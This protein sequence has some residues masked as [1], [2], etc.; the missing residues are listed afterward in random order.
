MAWTYSAGLLSS[1]G[2]TV[3]SPDSLL[4]GIAIAQASNG[5][6]AYRSG[7]VAWL[8]NTEIRVASGSFIILDDDSQIE[9]TGAS[10]INPQAGGVIHGNRSTLILSTNTNRIDG[11][12]D[13]ETGSTFICRRQR[14]NDPSPKIVFRHTNRHDYPVIL[15]GS[16]P[17]LVDIAGLD[18]YNVGGQSGYYK[19]YF[20]RATSANVNNVRFFNGNASL[21]PQFFSTTYNDSYFESL[22][23]DSESIIGNIVLNRTS[24]YLASPAA[25]S[26]VPR[27]ANIVLNNT[28][29][30][31]NCW[32]GTFSLS[33][34]DPVFRFASNYSYTNFMR[35]G[36]TPMQNVNLQFKR[37]MQSRNGNAFFY[38]PNRMVNATSNASGTYTAPNLQDA[39]R[40]GSNGTILER[41]NWTLKARRYD[42]RTA[43]ETV[44][45][46]RVL[47]QHSVNMSAGYSEEVQMLDVPN[48][49][50]TE[51]QATALTGISMPSKTQARYVILSQTGASTNNVYVGEVEVL[52][53]GVN[54]SQGKTATAKYADIGGGWSVSK[55]VDGNNYRNVDGYASSA[56]SDNWIQ[57]D[58]GQNYDID[59]ISVHALG[60]EA[61]D[62]GF[63]RNL[64]IFTSVN[65]L[66]S[67][68]YAQLNAGSGGAVSWGT[69]VQTFFAQNFTK[70]R[71]TT[72]TLSANRTVAELW[73]YYRAWISQTANFDVADTWTYN[74]TMLNVGAWNIVVNNGTTLTGNFT[75]TGT[76]TNNGTI[77][78]SY[79]DTAGTR[80]IIRTSDNLALSTELLIDGTPQGWQTGQTARVITVTPSSVVRIYAHAYGYQPKIINITGN[81]AS[82]Y[83]I[84]LVP[85]TNVDT[86]QSNRDTIAAALG[87]GL[88]TNSRIFLSVNA[89]LRSYTPAQVLH[90]LHW[91]VLNQG[92]VIALAA[93]IAGDL[94]GFALQ[95][96]GFIV[97]TP[98]FYGKVADSVTTVGNLGILVPLSIYV[99]PSVYVTMPTYTAVEKN[100][101][102]IVLQYAPWT[103]QEAD[104][105]A[106]VAKQTSLEVV[107]NGVKKAS[108]LIP[109]TDNV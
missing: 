25:F 78:G 59:E 48:L 106:W 19:M 102:G 97:R 28:T 58:L 45:S 109:H 22:A 101:S 62:D 70:T 90:A 44:F 93:L 61:G 49:T 26:G 27:S 20:G 36:L 4:S 8:A 65:P 68:T 2:A 57:I 81:T 69:T 85:E 6:I 60:A 40:A 79:T 54:V 77:N 15:S 39:Y 34:A 13:F 3:S 12:A 71:A 107:N 83:I 10:F 16:T 5:S 96:G 11:A 80:V 64:G 50:L 108:L 29:F 86:A 76:V 42:K 92:S 31:N 14:P 41:Y 47:F 74:G 32:N 23:L 35:Q 87:N 56:F 21:G 89:D 30:L 100:T 53:N 103:Q 55:V 72:L 98:G 104:V 52:S 88:D 51:A 18:L 37:A 94:N 82:D 99:D 43:A 24:Y 7:F 38:S 95:R 75:T 1:S 46:N 67:F 84:S 73:Q 33:Q 63:I 66:S 105:P 9:L 17:A 91:H